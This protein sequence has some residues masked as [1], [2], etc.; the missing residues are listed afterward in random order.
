[1]KTIKKLLW[2]IVGTVIVLSILLAVGIYILSP[3]YSG[4][5]ELDRLVQNVE[6]YYDNYGIPHIYAQDGEDAFT[7]L[8]YVHAQDRLWQMELLRRIG[9]GGLS[10]VFG[11]D[12][13]K[14]DKFFLTL[15]IDETSQKSVDLQDMELPMI[16][17]SQAYLD[18]INQFIKDGP[19]PIEF[20]LTGLKKSPFTLKDVYNTVGYMAFSF[21]MAHKTDPLLSNIKNKLGTAYLK[22]LEIDIDSGSALIQNYHPISKDSI[23][24]QMA[25]LVAQVL[26]K[27]PLPQF[28]GSNSW[29]IAPQKTTTGKVILANDP[30]IGFAQPSVWYEAHLSTPT[31][32]KY[33]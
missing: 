23:A 26:K 9:A 3:N 29:V 11:E 5:K 27:V 6:V 19:T 10:E 20:Y 8:G 15:G 24:N 1:M 13:L 33:G 30:H 18:G 7:A 21:A 14:T 31:Y 12:M 32:E 25:D 16:K 2:I 4:V 28:E 17:L 22:D